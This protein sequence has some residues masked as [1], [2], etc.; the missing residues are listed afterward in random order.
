ME[1]PTDRERP[2]REKLARL[3]RTLAF[4]LNF[5]EIERPFTSSD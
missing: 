2:T 1:Q 3:H 5:E 4:D